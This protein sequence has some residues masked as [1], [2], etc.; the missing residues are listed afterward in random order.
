LPRPVVPIFKQDGG[1]RKHFSQ[2][3][4]ERGRSRFFTPLGDSRVH[5]AEIE[6]DFKN[7][8]HVENRET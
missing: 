5:V 1:E 8:R 4:G 7:L 3:I 6:D 2:G